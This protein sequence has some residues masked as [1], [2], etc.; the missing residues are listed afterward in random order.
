MAGLESFLS[1]HAF[2]HGFATIILKNGG[3]LRSIQALLGHSHIQTTQVYT[4][5]QTQDLKEALLKSPSSLQK[6]A[7][8]LW[9]K[10]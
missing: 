8:D 9:E 1:P 2:R 4:H 7:L 3:D 6:K 10:P 5:L